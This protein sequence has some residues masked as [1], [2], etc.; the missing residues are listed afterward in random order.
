[1]T[2]SFS[3]GENARDSSG[4]SYMQIWRKKCK[5][6]DENQ[7]SECASTERLEVDHI[8]PFSQIMYENNIKTFAEALDCLELW[9]IEN[10]RTLCR[11]CHM[12]LLR[13]HAYTYAK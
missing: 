4:S 1:M 11:R 5:S 8:K 9:N 3:K 6:R 12:Q 7:C 2:T 10:G 13:P